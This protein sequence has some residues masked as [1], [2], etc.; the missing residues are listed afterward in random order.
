MNLLALGIP[1]RA[2]RKSVLLSEDRSFERGRKNSVWPT[3]NVRFTSTP[4]GRFAQI[5]AVH[6]CLSE[7]KVEVPSS[8]FTSLLDRCG[9]VDSDHLHAVD[10]L[11]RN[12]TA[13]DCAIYPLSQGSDRTGRGSD[14]K[15]PIIAARLLARRV[16]RIHSETS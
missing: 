13:L 6:R 11:A 4:A 15:Q 2:F 9:V 3:C 8:G 16:K 7:P 14:W 1:F 10:P 5:A 12:L